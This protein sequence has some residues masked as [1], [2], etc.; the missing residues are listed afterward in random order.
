MDQSWRSALRRLALAA[1]VA[2]FV[3]WLL[4]I[5]AWTLLA[6]FVAY[7]I[8]HLKQLRKLQLWL[9]SQ[10][11]ETPTSDGLWGKVLDDVHRLQKSHLQTQTRLK[12]VLTRVQDSTAALKDGVLMVDSHGNLEWWNKASNRLL[13]LKE[14]TD[15]GQPITNLVRDPN[16]K[17]YFDH[18]VYD[19]PLE[20]A[21]P[22]NQDITL[23]FHITLF[24]RRDRLILVQN[25][26]R[27]KHLEAMRQ[28]FVANVSHELR[29]PLTVITGYL[30]TFMENQDMLPPRWGRAL[31][32]MNQQSQ[33][34]QNLVNDLLLLS[35][36]ETSHN[37][38]HAEVHVQPMLQ[39][40]VRD[41]QSLS[42]E[43]QHK[44]SLESVDINLLGLDNELRSAFSNLVFNAV[45]YT[46]ANG[47][48]NVRY[49][50]DET[51]VYFSVQDNGIG[52]DS[53]HIPRLTERFYRADASRS[54]DTGGTGLG[55]AIVKHVLLR[56]EGRLDIQS[57]L[58]KGSTFICH[59]PL[60]RAIE[61]ASAQGQSA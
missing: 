29:T 15:L 33:R 13:G 43:R 3:G 58:G 54:M 8:W 60:K 21:S 47:M 48:I 44:I 4:D 20:I 37:Q 9:Q 32:Q 1:G 41:A 28:D 2:A 14:A 55:L 5:T 17:A 25:I 30:E 42:G 45:K 6:V 53:R 10:D 52:I 18:A 40:I 16:F 49:W 7:T 57:R 24:G 46:P 34:M 56:H 27:L 31:G 61:T 23:Q 35:R 50:Q 19:E 26:T 11:K 22:L 39:T 59:F 12:A 36:L 38:D 51:G